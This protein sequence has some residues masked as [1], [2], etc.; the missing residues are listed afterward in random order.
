MPVCVNCGDTVSSNFARVFGNNQNDVGGCVS[1]MS[2]DGL[3]NGDAAM[4]N[5]A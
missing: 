1:C 2:W 3:K 4:V 5:E